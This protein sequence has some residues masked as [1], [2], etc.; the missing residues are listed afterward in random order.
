[1]SHYLP[2]AWLSVDTSHTLDHLIDVSSQPWNART[3]HII[4]VL[5]PHIFS[6]I[7]LRNLRHSIWFSDKRVLKSISLWH[8]SYPHFGEN[9]TKRIANNFHPSLWMAKL[10]I[11]NLECIN[12]VKNYLIRNM[13]YEDRCIHN[14]TKTRLISL[15]ICHIQ[16]CLF[17]FAYENTFGYLYNLVRYELN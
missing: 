3:I 9:M 11:P 1:M 12:S 17:V 7:W 16:C 6:W 2:S 14:T 5:D 8:L 4:F 15:H 10:I 13:L